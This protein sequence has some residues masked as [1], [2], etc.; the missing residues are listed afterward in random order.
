MLQKREKKD[1][2][3]PYS[4]QQTFRGQAA[5]SGSA[6]WPQGAFASQLEMQTS[7]AQLDGANE[8]TQIGRAHV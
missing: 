6:Y 3:N 4:E 8:Q 2:Q 5:L 7:G 1:L